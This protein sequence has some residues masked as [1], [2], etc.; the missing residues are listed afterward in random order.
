MMLADAL[1]LTLALGLAYESGF[2]MRPLDFPPD[3]RLQ[4]LYILPLLVACRLLFLNYLGLYR[5]I[6]RYT[7]IKDLETIVI[8]CTAGTIGLLL[9]NIAAPFIPRLGGLPLHPANHIYRVPAQVVLVDFLLAIFGLGG[10]RLA[11]RM[12]VERLAGLNKEALRVLIIGAT[13]AGEQVARDLLHNY[14]DRFKPVAFADPDTTLLGRRIHG[15]P[16]AGTLEDLEEITAKFEVEMV[17]IALPRPTPGLLRQLVD[18]CKL[19]RLKFQIIPDL[20]SMMSGQVQFNRLR[21]VEI[22]DLLGRPPIVLDADLEHSILRGRVVLVTGAG[23][24]IGS[25]LCRQALHH[26][27]ERLVL[28]GRGENSLYEINAEL[29]ARARELG[30]M[31][32]VV[33][34]DVRDATLVRPLFERLRPRVILHAAAHKHVH[35]MEAQPAE[36]I[37]NNVVGTR[38]LAEAAVAVGAE[39][40]IMISTDKAV[41]PLGVM[42]ASKRVAETIVGALNGLGQTRFI[43][44]RFGNVLGSR[45]SVIPLFRR[46]I[47]AGGPVTVTHPDVTRYFM[48]I[49]EA[50]SLVL[51]A[52]ARGAGGEVFLLDMGQPIRIVDLARNL[53]T[54]SGLEPDRDIAIQYTG[55]RPGEKLYEELF[56]D[57][58]NYSRTTHSKILRCRHEAQPWDAVGSLVHRLEEAAWNGDEEMIRRLLHEIIPDFTGKVET[59]AAAETKD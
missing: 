23:G 48:T 12:I 38:L 8:A 32:E 47:A 15:L 35:F 1:V 33:V 55:L 36:A 6:A 50:V 56:T 53:I 52:G 26:R 19:A 22:E 51:E 10:V 20:D 5:S 44:V 28:L 24:S 27:P 42:G 39:R 21:P 7:S 58:E 16:I 34:G 57:M 4:F 43:A 9:F 11:R 59:P 37:K 2:S 29:G 3:F 46:Q 49:P 17:V 14:R 41:N 40:F 18:H 54:L 13:S 25:E 30:V 45:G 31:L